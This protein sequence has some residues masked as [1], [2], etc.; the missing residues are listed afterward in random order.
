[1]SAKSKRLPT[2]LSPESKALWTSIVTDYDVDDS[3]GLR[4]LQTACESLDL[5]RKAEERVEADGMT[6]K[7]RYGAIRGHPMLATI[8]DCRAAMLASLRALN[9][10]IEPLKGGPGRPPGR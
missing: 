5:M 10:D 7:D 4:F 6:V 1:M 9:L 2:T 3:A 8:R